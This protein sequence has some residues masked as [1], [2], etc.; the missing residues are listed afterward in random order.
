MSV[1]DQNQHQNI[2]R[3]TYPFENMKIK[4]GWGQEEDHHNSKIN[5]SE[6]NTG[7]VYNLVCNRKHRRILNTSPGSTEVFMSLHLVSSVQYFIKLGTSNRFRSLCVAFLMYQC[8]VGVSIE[9]RSHS[10]IST[11]CIG[12]VICALCFFFS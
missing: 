7:G 12:L 9:H 8:L 6:F 11:T 2:K 5:F 3:L 4:K 10:E 1:G